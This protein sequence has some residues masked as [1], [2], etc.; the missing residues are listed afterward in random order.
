[1]SPR[2]SP[3]GWVV[4]GL[5]TLATFC[6]LIVLVAGFLTK[7][8][9]WIAVGAVVGVAGLVSGFVALGKELPVPAAVSV[10]LGILTADVAAVAI[11]WATT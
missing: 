9:L 6:S 10:G 3:Y 5:L 2:R 8:D 4:E 11:M 7:V 1:M